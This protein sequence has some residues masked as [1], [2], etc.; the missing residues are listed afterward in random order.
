M[1]YGVKQIEQEFICPYCLERV[2]VSIDAYAKEQEF[3]EDCQVCCNPL[4]FTVK[5]D[6]EGNVLEFRVERPD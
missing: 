2:N 3:T 1:E 4:M 6:K 5:L